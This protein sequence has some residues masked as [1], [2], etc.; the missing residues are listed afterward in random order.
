MKEE[1][2][3][4]IKKLYKNEEQNLP[5]R[6]PVLLTF[7]NIEEIVKDFQSEN[8]N[9]IWDEITMIFKKINNLRKSSE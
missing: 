5:F 1:I 7:L 6:R 3:A 2:L 4:L 8:Y 9:I